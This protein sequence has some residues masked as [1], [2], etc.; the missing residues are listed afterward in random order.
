MKT[1]I[2]F[3]S[4]SSSTSFIV[5]VEDNTEIELHIK[6]DLARYGDVI[7]TKEGLDEYFK[8]K[9]WQYDEDEKYWKEEYDEC[10][11]VLGLGKKL[12]IGDFSDDSGDDMSGFLC[13]HGI[14]ESPGITVIHSEEGY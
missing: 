12:I 11:A 1:R 9:Y 13:N 5:G 3:I 7:D 4:N 10:V 6:V 14:P 8:D 2:G